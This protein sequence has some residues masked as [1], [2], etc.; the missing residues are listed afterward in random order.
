MAVSV[1][2]DENVFDSMTP[3]TVAMVDEI[4]VGNMIE[5]GFWLFHEARRAMTVAGM[6]WMDV[7][8]MTTSKSILAVALSPFCMFS[9][10]FMPAGVLAPPI[11]SIFDA[12]FIEIHLYA[13]SF[14]PLNNFFTMGLR[15]FESLWS[16]PVRSASF[17]TESHIEYMAVNLMS[18]F[19]APLTPSIIDG[20]ISV[21]FVAIIKIAEA[22]NK[23]VN[24]AFIQYFIDKTSLIFFFVYKREIYGYNISRKIL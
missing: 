10:A 5:D 12:R 7:A 11:P 1:S 13:S 2:F 20:K 14:S 22:R 16:S 19:I 21:G 23:R 24:T 3:M 9:I 17:N 8:L 6:S 4:K 15:R 18:R